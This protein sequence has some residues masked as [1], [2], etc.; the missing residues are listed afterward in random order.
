MPI[1]KVLVVDD[2]PTY[3]KSVSRALTNQSYSVVA[4]ENPLKA[5]DLIKKSS[6]DLLITD[7]KMP[8][9][10]GI[11]LIEK[12]SKLSPNTASLIMTAFASIETAVEAIKKGAFYYIPK[13]FNV[14]DLIHLSKKAIENKKL[15]D[16]NVYLNKQ[17]KRNNDLSKLVAL[18]DDIKDKIIKLSNNKTNLFI[19]GEIGTGKKTIAKT[20]HYNSSVSKGLFI[21]IDCLTTDKNNIEKELFGYVKG[22]FAG[23]INPQKG[24]IQIANEGTL[25]LENIEYLPMSI[26]GK[27]SKFISNGKYEPIGS[28]ESVSS[29]VRIIASTRDDVY[30]AIK[31]NRFSED[32]FYKLNAFL[33][34]IKPL[35]ERKEDIK[36][37]LDYFVK[38]FN[39]KRNKKIKGFSKEAMDILLNYYWPGNI[40]EIKNIVQRVISFTNKSYIEEKDIPKEFL[41]ENSFIFKDKNRKNKNMPKVILNDD[42]L[43]LNS[44]IKTLE[45]DIIMQALDK[46]KWNKNKAALLLNIKRTTLVE[47]LR[48]KGLLGS[49]RI[50]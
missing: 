13:P 5:I 22:A 17:I 2:E 37:I 35:R 34:K 12:V 32:L 49:R 39:L 3:R 10:N 30:I 43:D 23:A 11:E 31:E 14:E 18:S 20:I 21:H 9:I 28:S 42:G 47:K 29:N 26:Q 25:F 40:S 38:H 27:I 46:T 33:I 24:K 15:K 48:K 4:C 45:E 1:A 36:K 16:E 50:N 6:F 44:I 7:L 19:L 41:K 8:D